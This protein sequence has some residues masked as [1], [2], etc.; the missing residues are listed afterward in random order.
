MP[1]LTMFLF[2]HFPTRFLSS[3]FLYSIY[4]RNN[5]PMNIH[6]PTRISGV[7]III[8]LPKLKANLILN[9]DC[10][11]FINTLIYTE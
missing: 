2:I 3:F 11:S 1:Y 10:L 6:I 9:T 5:I 8:R 4:L 7:F